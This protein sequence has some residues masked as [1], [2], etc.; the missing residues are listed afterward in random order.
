[1]WVRIPSR[2]QNSQVAQRQ[3]GGLLNRRSRFRNSPWERGKVVQSKYLSRERR[4][5][6][7]IDVQLKWS[8]READTFEVGG[9]LPSTSTKIVSA[10]MVEW[11]TRQS[12]ELVPERVCG[13]ESHSRYNHVFKISSDAKMSIIPSA[14]GG[15]SGT[16]SR[17]GFYVQVVEWRMQQPAKLKKKFHRGFES[18]PVLNK[19]PCPSGQELLCKRRYTSSILVGTS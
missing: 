12:Q 10:Q 15:V 6:L 3:S 2:S 11:Y 1:M 8:E 18:L 16:E 4:L 7:D 14:Q 19:V 5:Y 13:F 17:R 9:S